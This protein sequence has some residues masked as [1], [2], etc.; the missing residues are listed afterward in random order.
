VTSFN[1]AICQSVPA[2]C[3]RLKTTSGRTMTFPKYKSSAAFQIQKHFNAMTFLEGRLIPVGFMFIECTEGSQEQ[4]LHKIRSIPA[5][6]YVYK[7]DKK[8]QLVVKIESD[9]V[10][11]F[12][13]AIAEIRKSGSLANTDTIIGFKA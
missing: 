6:S 4:L 5:V 2:D 8:Y 13:S 3:D 9:S 1:A 7:L 10:E 11:K 12:T